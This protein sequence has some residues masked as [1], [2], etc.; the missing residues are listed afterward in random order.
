M[1]TSYRITNGPSKDRIFDACKY[2]CDTSK[3]NVSFAVEVNGKT[4]VVN[5]TI[6]SVA[7]EDGSG[8][9]FMLT[10]AFKVKPRARRFTA[11]YS[12]KRR[13]GVVTSLD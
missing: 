2:A 8:E 1:E 9:S 5:A 13:E 10:G 7:H 6:L 3:I 12:S 4:N 11:Y